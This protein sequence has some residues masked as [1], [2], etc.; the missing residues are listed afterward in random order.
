M[1]YFKRGSRGLA[2]LSMGA[3]FALSGAAMAAADSCPS[4]SDIHDLLPKIDDQIAGPSALAYSDG[5]LKPGK[6]GYGYSLRET[7]FPGLSCKANTLYHTERTVLNCASPTVSAVKAKALYNDVLDCFIE[8]GWGQ[9]GIYMVDPYN[10]ATQAKLY[11][12][13]DGFSVEFRQDKTARKSAEWTA[14]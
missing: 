5:P 9:R 4:L 14:P 8:A 6:T 7:L 11:A 1:N 10:E 13:D 2:R 3:A 12:F